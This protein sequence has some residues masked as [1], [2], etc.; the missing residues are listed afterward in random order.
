[1]RHNSII[2]YEK[3]HSIPGSPHGVTGLKSA[4][5]I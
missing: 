2:R 4:A 1:M 3:P 5:D